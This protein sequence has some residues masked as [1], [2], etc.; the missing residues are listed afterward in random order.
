[1]KV[2]V[3]TLPKARLRPAGPEPA[4]EPLRKMAVPLTVDVTSSTGRRLLNRLGAVVR[5]VIA[6]REGA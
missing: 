1:M 6:G 2:V 3:I 5:R 4:A